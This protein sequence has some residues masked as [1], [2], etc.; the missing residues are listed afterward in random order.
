MQVND[1]KRIQ[2]KVMQFY[3]NALSEMKDRIR[4]MIFKFFNHYLALVKLPPHLH[5]SFP[6]RDR[7]IASYSHQE[8]PELFRFRTAEQLQR[9]L[10]VLNFP[11]K[12]VLEGGETF[13]GE[14]ILLIGLRRVNYPCKLIALVLQLIMENAT[15]FQLLD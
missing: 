10:K 1:V 9:M 3:S 13:T 2:M 11:E 15:L 8:I 7:T 14:E 12:V 5:M 4:P 6:R